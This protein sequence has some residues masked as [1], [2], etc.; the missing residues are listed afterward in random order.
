MILPAG[1]FNS[2]G[3]QSLQQ[4]MIQNPQVMQNMLQAPYMQ[5]MM[6]SLSANPDLAQQVNATSKIHRVNNAF[7]VNRI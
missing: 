4:Q 1:V 7:I 6:Q 5:A 2:P 3:I